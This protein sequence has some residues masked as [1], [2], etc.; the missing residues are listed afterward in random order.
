MPGQPAGQPSIIHHIP[1]HFRREPRPLDCSISRK[2]Q[3]T[4]DDKARSRC[5]YW[6]RGY[7]RLSVRMQ[8]GAHHGLTCQASE[9]PADQC[10]CKGPFQVFIEDSSIF[11]SHITSAAPEYAQT[12]M[13]TKREAANGQHTVGLIYLGQSLLLGGLAAWHHNTIV[14]SDTCCLTAAPKVTEEGCRAAN[15]RRQACT[16]TW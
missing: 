11:H 7:H 15:R 9:V 12:S 3:V 6:P 4:I 5:L 2:S 10:N 14:Q 13:I 8:S 16:W 1:M